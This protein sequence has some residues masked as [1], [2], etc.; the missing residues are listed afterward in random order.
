MESSDS[1]EGKMRML[2]L[3]SQELVTLFFCALC[4]FDVAHLFIVV[5]GE[6]L[7]RFKSVC[8]PVCPSEPL[9]V[10]FCVSVCHNLQHIHL[11][12]LPAR[13]QYALIGK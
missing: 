5:S 11:Y 7:N 12:S 2:F 10:D 9:F 6:L 8:V 13:T 4:G 1:A 3:E